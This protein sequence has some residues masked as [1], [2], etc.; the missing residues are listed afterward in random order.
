M[1][2]LVTETTMNRMTS[3]I[4]ADGSEVS[5]AKSSFRSGTCRIG[6]GLV[7]LMIDL[8]LR[9]GAEVPDKGH[10]LPELAF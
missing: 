5:G 9:V 8:Q 3:G 7:G 6:Y 2:R 10:K 4:R 1:S